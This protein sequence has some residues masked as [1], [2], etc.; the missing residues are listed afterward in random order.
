MWH[1]VTVVRTDFFHPDDR[2]ITF[3]RNVSHMASQLRRRHSSNGAVVFDDWLRGCEAK[4]CFVVQKQFRGDNRSPVQD[5]KTRSVENEKINADGSTA[6]FDCP[7][8]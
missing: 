7:M 6:T 2:G 4:L 8:V 5:L 3:L 1:H